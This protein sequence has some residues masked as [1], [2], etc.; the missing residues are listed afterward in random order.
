MGAQREEAV[1]MVEYRRLLDDVCAMTGL[2][3]GEARAAAE[4]TVTALA[5]ALDDEAREILLDAMPGELT[6]DFTIA[7]VERPAEA[8]DFVQRVA[9]LGRRPPAEARMR[10]Q[11]VLAAIRRQDPDLIDRLDLP[12]DMR[13]LTAPPDVGGGVVGPTGHQPE[14]TADEVRRE[15]ERL[16]DWTG[17]RSGLSRTVQLPPDSLDRVLGRLDL[18]RRDLGR[19][20][21]VEREG[22]T[23]VLTVRTRATG[24][25]TRL[26]VDLA[27]RIDEAIEEAGAGMSGA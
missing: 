27:H 7:G 15:L 22:D 11:A 18:L 24:G 6:D 2:G 10:A 12:D 3:A 4:T 9:L 23:A 16:P 14:L 17:D 25:V 13:A 21:A 5:R 1:V 19:G 20:P 8:T 26:D